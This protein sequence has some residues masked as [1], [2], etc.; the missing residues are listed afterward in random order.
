MA[1]MRGQCKETRGGNIV[2]KPGDHIIFRLEK[3]GETLDKKTVFGVTETAILFDEMGINAIYI[4]DFQRGMM[5]GV[6]SL[7]MVNGKHKES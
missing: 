7:K 6:L 3:G 5:N 1:F 4:A 2:P